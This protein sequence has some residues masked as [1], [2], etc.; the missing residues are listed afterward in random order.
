MKKL[1]IIIFLALTATLHISA[2]GPKYIFYFIG[3]GMGFG[4][5]S[6]AQVYNRVALG[7]PVP[8]TMMRLPVASA[9]FTHSASSPVTDSAAAGTA[10]ASGHK[11]GNGMLGVTPDTASVTSMATMLKKNGYGIGIVTSVA[12]DDATPGAF[13]AHQPSRAMYYEIGCDAAS[14]GFDFIAG[15]NLRGLKKSDGSPTDLLQVFED[16]KVAVVRGVDGLATARFSKVLL[17]DTDSADVKIPHTIDSVTGHLTLPVMTKACLDHLLANSPDRFFMMVE[18]GSIDHAAHANDAA[19]AVMET[20][21]FDEALSVV[22]DFYMQ[23]P[24]ETLIVVTADHET[25]GMILAN[26]VMHYDTHPERL[27]YVTMSKEAFSDYCK[28]MYRSRMVFTWDDMK[29]MLTDEMGLYSHIPVS[30]SDDAALRKKFETMFDL[31]NS[32]ADEASLYAS[33]NQFAVEVFDLINRAAGIGW[34][35]GDHSGTVVPVFAAGVGAYLFGHVLDNTEIPVKILQTV[36][37]KF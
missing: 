11:T 20:L 9:A 35:T 1:I 24:D 18:G 16:N 30:E 36:G 25:G 14:S 22:Y 6:A 3:D 13:F 33:F 29:R 17:L 34:S 37:L 28:S 31:R 23:H 2:S 27:Q 15:G 26:R 8:L 4:A 32:L 10:L 19:T 12:P 5:V 21:N 7:N